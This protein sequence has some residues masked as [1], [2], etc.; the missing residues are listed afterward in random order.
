MR[1]II[2]RYW[3]SFASPALKLEMPGLKHALGSG[4]VDQG[5]KMTV[6]ARAMAER[7]ASVV[8][9]S[10]TPPV[11]E[12]PEHDLDPVAAFVVFDGSVAGFS[13]QNAGSDLL[14]L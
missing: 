5:Q 7:R 9:R 3:H 4:L 2:F 10:D 8:A 14:R 1:R 13:A 11:F 6:A 12:T